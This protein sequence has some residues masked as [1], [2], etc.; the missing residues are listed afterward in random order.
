MFCM[1]WISPLENFYKLNIDVSILSQSDH[2]FVEVVSW[3]VCWVWLVCGGSSLLN[4][5]V[6]IVLF[7]IFLLSLT[8]L[9]WFVLL[10]WILLLIVEFNLSFLRCFVWSTTLIGCLPSLLSI[11]APTIVLIS[12][13]SLLKAN[14]LFA[15]FL[16]FLLSRCVFFFG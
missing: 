7:L 16:T 13:Q 12:L 6:S 3:I 9:W 8:R 1:V 14:L 5:R 2:P 10:Q 4:F 15:P 11:E